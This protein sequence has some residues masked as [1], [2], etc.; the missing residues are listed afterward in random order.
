MIKDVEVQFV[1]SNAGSAAT[2]PTI[3]KARLQ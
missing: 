1:G 2:L 3:K